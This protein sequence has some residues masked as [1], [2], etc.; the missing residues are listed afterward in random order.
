M[1]NCQNF[2]NLERFPEGITKLYNLRFLSLEGTEVTSVPPSIGKLRNLETLN[3]AETHVEELP[4]EI[5]KLRRL[6][7]II[8]YRSFFSRF[9]KFVGFKAPS[10]IETLTSLQTLTIINA[11]PGGVDLIGS[12][13]MLKQLR[14]LWIQELGAEHGAALCSSIQKLSCLREL[15]ME[16]R[17]E[18]E[19]LDL[20]N[21]S[22]P[23]LQYLQALYMYGCVKVLPNWVSKLSSLVVLELRW[24]NLEVD[25]LKS[26]QALPNLA[27]LRF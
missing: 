10:G 22:S 26:L 13:G 2:N 27:L 25:P 18:D 23:A 20:H 6:R 8:V 24:S 11:S 4:V 5:L 17:E 21:I 19:V 16:T 7:H 15:W 3:L 1:L 12:L 14:K 9:N